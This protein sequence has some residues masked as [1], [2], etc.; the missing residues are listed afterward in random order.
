MSDRPAT[1]TQ[2]APFPTML[3]DLVETFRYRPGW[4]FWLG[5]MDRGQGSEGLTL[6]IITAAVNSYHVNICETCHSAVTDYRVHHYMIVPAASYNRRSWRRWL[7]EQCFLVE[8]HEACE[9][10]DFGG[11][12]PFAPNHGPGNDPYLLVEVGTDLDRR[13]SFR[14]E[15]HP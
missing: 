4:R 11:D 8:Q 10:A 3:A 5:H 15:V 12:R 9:F 6:D 14:G 7:L 2:V 1:M 13:T